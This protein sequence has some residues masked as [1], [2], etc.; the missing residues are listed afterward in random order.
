MSEFLATVTS[1]GQ[2]TLPAE[3]RREFG[4]KTGDRVEILSEGEEIRIRVPKHTLE[5]AYGS[6]P[7]LPGIETGDFDDLIDAAMEAHADWVVDRTRRGD[8]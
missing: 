7:A 5:S 8:E 3:V 6:I 4:I 1:K 2:L